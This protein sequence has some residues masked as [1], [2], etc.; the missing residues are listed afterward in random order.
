MK[1]LTIIL[2]ILS[3]CIDTTK[4]WSSKD[5][6]SHGND[7]QNEDK[8]NFGLEYLKVIAATEFRIHIA[9]LFKKN[10]EE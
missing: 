5:V 1:I 4:S 6:Y 9:E 3:R 7:F 10:P 2:Q 8:Q